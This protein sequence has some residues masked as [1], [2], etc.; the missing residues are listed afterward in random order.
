MIDPKRHFGY[1]TL[2]RNLSARR[3]PS[4]TDAYLYGTAFPPPCF[5]EDT[6]AMTHLFSAS[7]PARIFAAFLCLF[8]VSA[9]ETLEKGKKVSYPKDFEDRR[10]ERM[11]SLAGPDGLV[12]FG[13]K[14]RRGGGE[15]G[16]GVNSYLWRATLDTL[17]FLPLQS[18]DPFGGTVITDWY[19]DPEAK[20]E[21]FKVNAFITAKELRSDGVRISLFRQTEKDGEW[22]DAPASDK[23]AA[24]IED[25]ILARAKTLKA[26]DF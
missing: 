13:D 4:G 22:R 20:G 7:R 6:A 23:A 8:T 11:G 19:E 15:A 21:R 18:A 17:S 5:D 24:D 1:I 2:S 3:L 25:R 10:R 16:I 26:S 9:C 14:K 12:L